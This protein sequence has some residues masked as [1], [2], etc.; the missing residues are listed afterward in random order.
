[1]KT[2]H[3]L[4]LYFGILLLASSLAACDLHKYDYISKYC[5]GSCTVIKGRMTDQDGK[6]VAGTSMRIK[7]HNDGYL[8]PAYI[9]EKAATITDVN[10][11][12]ELRFLVRD[13][14]LEKGYYQIEADTELTDY[15]GCKADSR[16]Y[17]GDIARDTTIIQ[18]YTIAP[19]AVLQFVTENQD[20][21]QPRERCQ[22]LVKYK[23]TPTDTDS[24]AYA[25]NG[26]GGY[27]EGQVY[28]PAN[29]P[30]VV[31]TF[32]TGAEGT[33]KDVLTLQPGELRRYTLSF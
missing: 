11:G 10:G 30:V 32:K 2:Y 18:N 20:P 31:Y 15:L 14:E 19:S 27:L 6:P 16:W 3:R 5:P 26:R 17:S 21:D 25:Y 1:M 22:A 12:Y 13:S 9:T 4:R 7:W 24:C 23:L 8:Q 29:T 28:V 33:K